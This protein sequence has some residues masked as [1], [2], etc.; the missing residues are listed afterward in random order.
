[1]L[2]FFYQLMQKI[3]ENIKIIGIGETGLDFYYNHSSKNRQI[4]S[5]KAHIEGL[6]I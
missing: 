5:F 2:G 4:D 6:L 1:M 3:K